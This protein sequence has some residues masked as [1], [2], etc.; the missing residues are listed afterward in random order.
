MLMYERCCEDFPHEMDLERDSACIVAH[1]RLV[2]DSPDRVPSSWW[3]WLSEATPEY[4]GF[5]FG[6]WFEQNTLSYE[7]HH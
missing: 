2:K 7:E 5:L 1:V 3:E 4:L 6:Q